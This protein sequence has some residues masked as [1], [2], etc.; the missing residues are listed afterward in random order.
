MSYAI[1]EGNTITS[2][3]KWAAL[4]RIV[5]V[6]CLI[7]VAA[8][9][10]VRETGGIL[11]HAQSGPQG[12]VPD[13][14]DRLIVKLR[15]QT[16][17]A[18]NMVMS[19]DQVNALSAVAGVALSSFR[20]M[21]GGAQVLM[22]PYWMT[23]G[24]AGAI[25][26][27]LS[28]DPN[29]LY[30]EPDRIMRPMLVPNDPL[31][32]NQDSTTGSVGIFIAVIDTGV[33][34]MHA[35]LAG[36]TVAGFD[37][38]SDP[39]VANDGGGRDADPTDPG[40]WNVPGECGIG[41]PPSDSSWHGT[42]VAGTIAA[43]SNNNLGV[44]GINWV[45]QILP[46]RVLGKCGGFL[47]DV[48]DGARW[49]AGLSVPGVLAN[50]NPAHVLNLSLGGSGACGIT[51][52][53]AIN[54]IVAA[55]KVVVVAAGN[56]SVDA[57]TVSPAS[58]NGVITVAATTRTGSKAS[59]SNFGTVVEI[60][61]PGGEQSFANDP[62]GVMSTL[63]T[64]TTTAVADDYRFY[65]G[66]SMSTPHVAGIVSLML[67]A[68]P[69]LT[70]T[71]VLTNMQ[72]TAR[73]FPDATCTTSICGAGIIDAAAAVGLGSRILK[74]NPSSL[75]FA[76][77]LVGQTTPAQSIILTNT[78]TGTTLLTI[79]T[80]SVAGANVTDFTLTADTCS[81]APLAPGGNCSISVSFTPSA[82]GNRTASV[83]IPSDAA[84]SPNIVTLS[85][86]G[87]GPTI[88]IAATDPDAAEASL[89]PGVFTI[90]RTGD[91]SADLT[92]NYAV[93]GTA[94]SG[95]DYTAL[96]GS[97]NIMTGSATATI[98]VTPVDDA[99]V[100]GSE[101]LVLTLN[102]GALYFVGAAS[103]ATVTI[104]DND[105]APPSGGG[106]PCF[107]AT[108]A[109]GSPLAHEVK[110]LR[111]FRD[112]H[113][114]TTGLGRVLVAAYYRISPPLAA[115]IDQHEAVRAAARALL[116]PVVWWAH[117]ALA[118][119]ALALVLGGGA[120]LAGGLVPYHLLRAGRARGPRWRQVGN[121]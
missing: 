121:P 80:A 95:T 50:S 54:E 70:S 113:L 59:Y 112:R 23:V 81:S 107:I 83:T 90:T 86:M 12:Q 52:Q 41:S 15:N 71:D 116:W 33:L 68:N 106:G 102:P 69:A 7:L 27:T 1:N 43:A 25:A 100:E 115:Q 105:L 58:C 35:D 110:V 16:A 46:V 55:G 75:S 108:A 63:N 44:A 111:Q 76:A 11:V 92:V 73:A 99:I 98:T 26:Q 36:R 101:T 40:D 94:T 51:E 2:E 82:V 28:A 31:Y 117:L 14:T 61:A 119:P 22:L 120:L 47:S 85:G 32:A 30:A 109:Y 56:E 91:T 6:V 19:V 79:G 88:T 21:S 38:I 3:K 97:V 49:A 42:H 78:N 48:V 24:E 29:V 93:S 64:G 103:S 18:Q 87:T 37:F 118:S 4:F 114:L 9:P 66:T 17:P 65:Q 77:T 8:E 96:T 20:P 60:S 74:S 5:G 53:D 89:D 45:S 84:Y 72:S 34:L 10:S 57:A 67:S 104:T 39:F 13:Y 62:D